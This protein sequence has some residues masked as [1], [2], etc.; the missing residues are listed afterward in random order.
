MIPTNRTKRAAATVA[1]GALLAAVSVV[2]VR[3]WQHRETATLIPCDGGDACEAHPGPTS[4]PADPMRGRP[5]LLAFSSATCVACARMAPIVARAE[6]ACAAQDSVLHLDLDEDT[7]GALAATYRV[8]SIPAWISVD[9]D[10][11]E[12]SRLVG[13]QSLEAIQQALEEVR[14]ARCARLDEPSPPARPM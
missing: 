1:A 9:S 11:H 6:R 13:V 4:I 2:G 14:G 3:A 7:G 10:G 12:V 8:T 5:R